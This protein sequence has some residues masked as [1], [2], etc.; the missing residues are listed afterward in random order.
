MHQ[1][2]SPVPPL[3]QEFLQGLYPK[4]S[5][6]AGDCG[7]HELPV[8]QLHH[9]C[10]KQF[11][12]PWD[13]ELWVKHDLSL[14]KHVTATFLLEPAENQSTERQQTWLWESCDILSQGYSR[15]FRA[16]DKCIFLQSSKCIAGYQIKDLLRVPLGLFFYETVC[17]VPKH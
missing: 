17:S 1:E 3:T 9:S 7:A 4:F 10:S 11:S 15:T 6:S 16:I 2:T 12:T 5:V 8:P 14:N 13:Y